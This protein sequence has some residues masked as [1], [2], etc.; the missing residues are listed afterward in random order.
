M[1]KERDEVRKGLKELKEQRAP[2]LRKIQNIDNRLQPIHD[3][4]KEMVH[5]H[6]TQALKRHTHKYNLHNTHADSLSKHIKLNQPAH[7]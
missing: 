1:K 7:W 6:I 5:T 4:I 2:M 3:Q